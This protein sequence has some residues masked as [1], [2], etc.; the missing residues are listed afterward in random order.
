MAWP[1]SRIERKKLGFKKYKFCRYAMYVTFQQSK[2][3]SAI[4]EEKK[5]LNSGQHTLYG[6]MVEDSVLI[7]GLTIGY[8]KHY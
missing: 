5:A 2:R 7:T 1:M 3:P 4:M 6:F 8:N